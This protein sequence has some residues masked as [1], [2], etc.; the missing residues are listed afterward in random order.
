MEGQGFK[1][2]SDSVVTK[3]PLGCVPGGVFAF[4]PELNKRKVGFKGRMC[5]NADAQF[6]LSPDR[7]RLL[8]NYD[9]PSNDGICPDTVEKV[10]ISPSIVDFVK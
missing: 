3:P 5:A 8:W 2:I 4:R 6:H 1:A 9:P 7:S 10:G